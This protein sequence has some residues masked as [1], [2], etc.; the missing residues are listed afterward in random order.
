M[1]AG[2]QNAPSS[3]TVVVAS[4]MPECSPPMMPA[5]PSGFFSSQTSSR[6]GSRSSICP[7]SSVSFSPARAKRTTMRAVEQAIVVG[8]QRLAQLEHH[9]VGDVDDR[10]DRADAAALEALLH[11]RGRRRPRHR[12]PRSMRRHEARAGGRVLD[13][14]RALRRGVVTGAGA[15]AGGASG[16]PVTAATRARCR[17][18]TGSR[19]GSA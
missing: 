6:S 9:V 17:A 1:T 12:C 10:R 2:F 7:F 15:I 4:L 3:S 11:P 19:R 5:R 16:A 8:V 14:H 13:A 18:S